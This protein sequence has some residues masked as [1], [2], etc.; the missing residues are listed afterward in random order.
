M[1]GVVTLGIFVA[2]LHGH[3]LSQAPQ[4]VAWN[5]L[6]APVAWHYPA[7]GVLVALGRA[8]AGAEGS[9]LARR[10]AVLDAYRV[11]LRAAA[12]MRGLPSE[13]V[14]GRVANFRV[15]D[16]VAND[17]VLGVYLI[18]RLDDVEV[19]WYRTRDD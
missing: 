10:G 11:L 8:P 3:A 9:P 4:A 19:Q 7:E 1:R 2:V 5:D 6:G 13:K 17:G 12:W 16:S 15:V 14:A 18:A